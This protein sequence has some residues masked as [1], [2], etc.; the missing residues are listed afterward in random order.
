MKARIRVSVLTVALAPTVKVP[1]DVAA[2]VPVWLATSTVEPVGNVTA[3]PV[4]VRVPDAVMAL[5]PLA[6]MTRMLVPVTLIEPPLPLMLPVTPLPTAE[7][8]AAR[9]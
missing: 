3:A 4:T 6:M 2:L 7:V 5:L 8:R 9:V 1:V